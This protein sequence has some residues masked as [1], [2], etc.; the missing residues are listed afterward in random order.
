MRAG[1]H[2]IFKSSKGQYGSSTYEGRH[3]VLL[4]HIKEVVI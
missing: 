2:H 3:T 4:P 1:E